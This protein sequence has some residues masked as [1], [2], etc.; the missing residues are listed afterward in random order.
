MR[1]AQPTKE[2]KLVVLLPSIHDVMALERILGRQGVFYDLIPVPRQLS[3][4]CGMAVESLGSQW[5]KID[6]LASASLLRRV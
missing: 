1:E 3:S 2:Q 5:R 4:E 6:A